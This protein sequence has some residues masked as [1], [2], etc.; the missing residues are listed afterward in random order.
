MAVQSSNAK[1]GDVEAGSMDILIHTPDS[2]ESCLTPDTFPYHWLMEKWTVMASTLPLWKGRKNVTISYSQ[3]GDQPINETFFDQVQFSWSEKTAPG[4]APSTLEGVDTVRRVDK[5]EESEAKAQNGVRYRWGATGL[6][7]W[8]CPRANWQLL[9]FF[10]AEDPKRSDEDWVVMYFDKTLFTPAGLDI[11]VCNPKAFNM[12]KVR[13]IIS[14]C[15]KN[16]DAAVCTCS[17]G[18]FEVPRDQ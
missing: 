5:R 4:T 7:A 11:Y 13:K 12:S 17:E 14:A 3:I 15:Q 2:A 16:S 1:F 18:F 8:I 6:M 9:G 10:L